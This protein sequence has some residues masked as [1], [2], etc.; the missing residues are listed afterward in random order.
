[1]DVLKQCNWLIYGTE[2]VLRNKAENILGQNKE[3]IYK[4]RYL[5]PE[6]G[7]KLIAGKL[8][9][10]EPFMAARIGFNE[11]SMMKAYDFS[12]KDKFEN[13]LTNMCD[14]AGFFPKDY[15][16]GYRFLE[17]MEE[18]MREAD[19]LAVMNSPFEEYYVRHYMK[20]DSA[21]TPFSVMEFWT[22]E[23]SWT[24]ALKG[25]K[26]LVVNPFEESI[27]KQYPKRKE[28]FGEKQYLPDIELITYKA[29]Q[30]AG[31]NEDK[32]FATW[33]D[34]LEFMIEEI[35]KLEF[36]TAILGCGAY[37]FPMAA[38][39]KKMGKQV[40]HMGGVSQILFGIKGNRWMKK[41][42]TIA[43]LM[44]ENWIFPSLEETP[45]DVN[46]MEGGPYFQ[47]GNYFEL[48]RGKG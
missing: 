2:Y 38:E 6:D 12:K 46:R 14:A 47:T 13:V 11:M 35:S 30:T 43:P 16:L 25:K 41:S 8:C 4:R 26:V 17:L 31:G 18:S 32:R 40:I 24:K 37:G 15:D 29:V 28:L 19:L 1:M 9:T 34:A 39:I 23:E 10:D 42:S 45:R 44:N 22:L 33:F 21:V 3:G 7:S 36:D 27:K 20:K 5:E 48:D